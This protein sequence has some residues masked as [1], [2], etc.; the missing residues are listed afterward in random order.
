MTN[1]I[2]LG[3]VGGISNAVYNNITSNA[4]AITAISVGATTINSSA[5]AVGGSLDVNGVIRGQATALSGDVLLIGDNTKLVDINVLDTAGLYSQSNTL[6]GSL[7]FGS[8]GGIISGYNGNIGIGTVTPDSKLAVTGTANISG[9]VVFGS[10]IS[11]NGSF[12]TAG[13]ALTSNGAGAYWASSVAPPGGW[14]YLSTV[15]ASNVA[16]ADIE[17]TFDS[18]YDNYVIVA[19][20]VYPISSTIIRVRFKISGS[21]DTSANYTWTSFTGTGDTSQTSISING[22]NSSDLERYS[23]NFLMYIYNPSSSSVNK[24]CTFI[25]TMYNA[26]PTQTTIAST[27]NFNSTTPLTGVRFFNN[28][29]NITG[30]FRLYGIKKS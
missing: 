20:G 13:Q 21:Y 22:N 23:S 3:K 26:T 18:T 12:G 4:T 8:N 19:N 25:G 7:K 9:N 15:T 28:A 24:N 1:A 5:I 14:V 29:G 17:T 10:G 16:T 11:V 27:A 6:I 2:D 30:T